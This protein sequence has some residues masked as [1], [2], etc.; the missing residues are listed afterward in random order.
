MEMDQISAVP[1]GTGTTYV[2][3]RKFEDHVLA[4]T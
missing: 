4:T 3:T 1:V 2:S